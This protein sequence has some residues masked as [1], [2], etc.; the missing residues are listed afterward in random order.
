MSRLIILGGGL[1]VLASALAAWWTRSGSTESVFDPEVRPP[2]ATPLCPWREPVSD[3]KQFFPNATSYEEETRILS[4][5]RVEL[6]QRLGRAPTSDETAL[7]VWRVHQQGVVAGGV[8]TRRV[9]GGHG[10]IELVLAVDPDE[11]VHGMRL[12]R[13]REPETVARALQDPQW[14][15]SFAGR[16][17]DSPWNVE[18]DIA[19]LPPAARA[20]AQAIV[21][22]A[23][24]LL[25]LLAESNR[26]TPSNPVAPHH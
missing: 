24:S 20:S 6:E 9:K 15:R 17:A 10:A 12:Q 13:L 14:L 8:L 26:A 2:E 4:G 3:L 19:V 18:N 1:A 25:I 21:E 16:R 22:A 5:L 7:H 11:R 23:R